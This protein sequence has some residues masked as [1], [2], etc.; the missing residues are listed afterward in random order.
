MAIHRGGDRTLAVTSRLIGISHLVTLIVS[1]STARVCEEA[2]SCGSAGARAYCRGPTGTN[3]DA[4][5]LHLAARS[6]HCQP[7]K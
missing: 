2:A 3:R 5:R 1:A 7:E 6:S 4:G